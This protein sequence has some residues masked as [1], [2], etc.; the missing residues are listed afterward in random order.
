MLQGTAGPNVSTKKRQANSSPE[1]STKTVSSKCF[2]LDEKKAGAA[3]VSS[4][5]GIKSGPKGKKSVGDLV[6]KNKLTAQSVHSSINLPSRTGETR[7]RAAA[8]TQSRNGLN[9]FSTNKKSVGGMVEKKRVGTPLLK[10]S[11]NLPSGAVMSSNT[12]TAATKPRNG[13][14]FVAKVMK[15]VGN[16]VAKRPTSRSLHMSINLPSGAAETSKTASVFGQN[17]IKKVR[18]NLP[19]HNPVALRASTE[20]LTY[21]PFGCTYICTVVFLRKYTTFEMVLW[22][23]KIFPLL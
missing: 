8:A 16:S 17:I 23:L 2:P 21:P 6:E 3:A 5:S 12:D 9:T 19:K 13:T 15:S 14:N 18:S 10:M 4:R 11:I 20:V 1:L 7:K 22:L